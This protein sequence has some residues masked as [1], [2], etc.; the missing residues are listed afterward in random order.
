MVLEVAASP[1]GKRI[2]T[3]IAA[4]GGNPDIW[5]NEISNRVFTR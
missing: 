2:A 3:A 4:T 1:D 5:V